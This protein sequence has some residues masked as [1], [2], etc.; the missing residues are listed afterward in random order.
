[1]V[2]TGV[3]MVGIAAAAASVCTPRRKRKPGAGIEADHEQS[4]SED[5]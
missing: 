4:G 1:L 2:E 3:G 5:D